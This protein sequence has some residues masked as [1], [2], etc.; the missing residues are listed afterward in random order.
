MES[1]MS[2]LSN[3][4]MEAYETSK[5]RPSGLRNLFSSLMREVRLRRAMREL[6]AL[7]DE[8]LHDIGLGPGNIEDAVRCG[9]H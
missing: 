6:S 9:R 1:V 8:M 5:A 2:D 4:C 3:T 7:D